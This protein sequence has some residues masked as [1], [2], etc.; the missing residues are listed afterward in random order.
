MPAVPLDQMHDAI[1]HFALMQY[2]SE[3][4]GSARKMS[5][6]W[7]KRSTDFCA[8]KLGPGVLYGGTYRFDRAKNTA[9]QIADGRFHYTLEC[10]PTSLM[11]RL[12]NH[13]YV[14]TKFIANALALA[15]CDLSEIARTQGKEIKSWFRNLDKLP[16]L[17]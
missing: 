15:A 17:I 16:M 13:S 11:E 4:A 9:A 14:D 7:K 6:R 12:T 5:K 1:T 10:H 2:S 8:L 3:P